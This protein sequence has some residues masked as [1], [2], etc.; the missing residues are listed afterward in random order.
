MNSSAGGN[1]QPAG[2][3]RL[4]AQLL[5][6]YRGWLAIAAVRT[7]LMR[8]LDNIARAPQVLR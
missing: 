5:R 8:I 7:A 2:M 4:I 3:G 6:P 1:A